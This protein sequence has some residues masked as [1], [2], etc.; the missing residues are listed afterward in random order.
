MTEGFFS[1]SPGF[2]S[3]EISETFSCGG[4]KQLSVFELSVTSCEFDCSFS[5]GGDETGMIGNS[6]CEVG[7][8]G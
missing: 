5:K 3:V 1:D 8:E 4:D 7:D 6:F 2:L